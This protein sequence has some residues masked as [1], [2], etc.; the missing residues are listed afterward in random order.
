MSSRGD[1]RL[2]LVWLDVEDVSEVVEWGP[3]SLD[4]SLGACAE[5]FVQWMA[6]WKSGESH[7]CA[8]TDFVEE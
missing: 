8:V 4:V 3:V 7:G 1:N 2:D 5:R 6:V